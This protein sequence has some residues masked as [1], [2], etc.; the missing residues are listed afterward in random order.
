MEKKIGGLLTWIS[1]FYS[2]ILMLI[3]A[4]QHDIDTFFAWGTCLIFQVIHL[5]RL[6]K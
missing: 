6:H 2:I 5:D 4:W 3:N 1:I